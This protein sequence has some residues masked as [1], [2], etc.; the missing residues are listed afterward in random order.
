[1]V[2]YT[3]IIPHFNSVKTIKKLIKS[4]PC[5]EE[6]QIIIVD[7]RSDNEELKILRDYC[8]KQLNIELLE[9]NTNYKGAG[10]CRN[11]GLQKAKGKWVLFADSDDFFVK[12]FYS[13]I[14]HFYNSQNDII[15]FTPT[16]LNLNSGNV[17]NRHL[18]YIGLIENYL[19]N[20]TI[21]NENKLK[22]EYF[23]PWSKMIRLDLIR[24]NGIKFDN[25]IAGND[26][27]FSTKISYYS[28]QFEICKEVI[29]C[30]T[31]SSESLTK[32]KGKHFFYSRLSVWIRY[33]NFLVKKL[34]SNEFERLDV[35]GRTILI[36]AIKSRYSIYELIKIYLVLRKNNLKV[37][38]KKILNPFY[39]LKI[40]KL[41]YNRVFY[42]K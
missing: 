10:I 37:F 34:P 13:V 38:N 24:D 1:M 15:Y 19:N 22:Y 17:S 6:I 36:R 27:M 2:K 3:I 29:Y 25:V 9:N 20:P 14:K 31:K 11:I 30:V 12:G 39:I 21:L 16:S 32:Q 23:V 33:H 40:V 28:R 4:I 5:S 35:S 41:N 18:S 42:E 26:V 7:D 8:H